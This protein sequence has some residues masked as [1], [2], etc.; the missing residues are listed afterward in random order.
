MNLMDGYYINDLIVWKSLDKNGWV[1][2]GFVIDAP[3]LRNAST[4]TLMSYEDKLKRLI[5]TVQA[6]ARTQWQWS[7][8][9]DYKDA[10]ENYDTFT[11]KNAKNEWSRK[12]R[13]E[14]YERYVL[15]MEEGRLRREKLRLYISIPISS[16]KSEKEFKTAKDL[17]TFYDL[18]LRSLEA[19]YDTQYHLIQHVFGQG[20]TISPMDD[21]QHYIHHAEF[22]NPSFARRNNFNPLDK[23]DAR[24][25]IMDNC[26]NSG[27]TGNN[28]SDIDDYGFYSDGYYYNVLTIS[29]WPQQ[30]YQSIIF[31]ITGQK[32]L[33]Y[34]ISCTI[35]PGDVKEEIKMEEK[36]IERLRGDYR[37]TQ[38]E[39]LLNAINKKAKKIQNLSSG[40]TFPLT[41]EYTITLWASSK[42]ELSSKTGAMKSA[43]SI[44]DSCQNFEPTLGTQ[45]INLL[46]QTVPGW[47]F[48]KYT[49]HA[50]YGESEYVGAM[51][52][53][54]ST[55][56]GHLEN[57][58]AL[59][60]GDN[61]NLVGI[62]NFIGS[63]PQHGAFFGMSGSGKSAQ[64]CDMLSQTEPYYGYT[65][66]IEEGLSYGVYTAT[67]GTTPIIIHPD[68]ELV[69]N[70]FDTHGLPLSSGQLSNATALVAQMC[71]KGNN[72]EDQQLRF[73]MI[74]HYVKA[75]YNDSFRTWSLGNEKKLLEIARFTMAC[76]KYRTEKMPQASSPTD[77]FIEFTDLGREDPEEQ[78]KR[79]AEYSLADVTRYIKQPETSEKVENFAFAWFSPEDFPTHS[80]LQEGMIT[81]PDPIHDA[82]NLKRVSTLISAW[83]ADGA[84]GPL[85][86]GYTNI[87]LTGKLAHFELG[88]I[89][90][91]TPELKK[92]AAFL[93][94]NYTRN[95]IMAL[96]RK[97]KKRYIFEEAGRLLNMPGGEKLISEGYAQMR[98]FGTWIVSLVQQYTQFKN[99]AIRPIIMGN[100]KQ[101]FIMKQADRGDLSDLADQDR[102]GINIPLITQDTIMDYPSPENLPR[103]DIYSSFTYFHS[104]NLMP[105]VGTCRNYCAPEMLYCSSS[106]GEDFDK[107]MREIKSMDSVVEAIEHYC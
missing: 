101:F 69:I 30:T 47:C 48:G 96:P 86:D 63:T 92:L 65:V 19:Y 91:A 56:V 99:T 51:L 49:A 11:R 37:A 107:R 66:I 36:D 43:L 10:L 77:S 75:S 68:S 29:R 89:P 88:Y 1:S 78:A 87:E 105:L 82:D 40:Y 9:S 39:S 14:R 32:Y 95:H 61:F 4:E 50:I 5:L 80:E 64:M 73:A 16:N 38:K 93:I 70:Y 3:D 74:L 98:K 60:D 34:R 45:S 15:R 12:T 17:E 79:L 7:V 42:E 44:M 23:F 90:E 18:T 106:S 54:S 25:S 94:T 83:N 59:Y 104:D 103:D 6:P 33:D 81:S 55:F 72:E 35:T 27:I 71:G 20:T 85:F 26:I 46:S 13:E 22:F 67:M 100:S 84:Y 28:R 102:G 24:L 31:Q 21:A 62:R 8:N 2:K 58:E 76:E 52:P 97:V 53:F 41:A 57:A